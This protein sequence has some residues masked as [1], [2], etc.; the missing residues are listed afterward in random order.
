[1]KVEFHIHTN[2]SACSN[3]SLPVLI[4]KAQHFNI[5]AIV[6][7][8]HNTIKGA[9]KLAHTAPF[10][11]II[12]EEIE[13][14]DGEI[15]GL[16]LKKNIPQGLSFKKAISRIRSQGG[17]V[18]LHHPFDRFRRKRLKPQII[19]KSSKVFD[20]VE[21]FN[22]RTYYKADNRKAEIWAQKHNKKMIVGSDAHTALELGRTFLQM[23]DF[24]NAEEFLANINQAEFTT[25]KAEPFVHL[26]TFVEKIK[27]KIRVFRDP[28]P[29]GRNSPFRG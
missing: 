8:D 29:G 3:L 5:N 17:L 25:F 16:F 28:P 22:G 14:R 19:E 23:P 1:M 10:K 2:Y 24:A 13:T 20:L 15:L 12:G 7:C 27:S 26:I 4:K 9:Q 11:V 18:C 6:V 21:I